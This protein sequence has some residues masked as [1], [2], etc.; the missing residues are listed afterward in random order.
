MFHI[1]LISYHYST[2]EQM[3]FTIPV[4]QS[5]VEHEKVRLLEKHGDF[6][7]NYFY[8]FKH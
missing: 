4:Q 6:T 8:T 7:C 3:C 5:E 2:L 1:A